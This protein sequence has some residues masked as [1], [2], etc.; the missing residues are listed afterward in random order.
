[1]P[2]A[3]QI[4]VFML[5]S[6]VAPE[7]LVGRSVVVIDVLRAT[8]TIVHALASGADGGL[9]ICARAWPTGASGATT[10]ARI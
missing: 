1:M 10:C 9:D 5:P 3:Q 2:L 7:D 4:N 8:T 6:L